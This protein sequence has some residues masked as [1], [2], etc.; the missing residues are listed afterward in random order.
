[1]I[2]NSAECVNQI[3]ICSDCNQALS[4]ICE[5]VADENNNASTL[6]VEK[7][8]THQRTAKNNKNYFK[9]GGSCFEY[10]FVLQADVIFTNVHRVKTGLFNK[11]NSVS[12]MYRWFIL[13]AMEH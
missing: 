9:R 8:K 13:N 4:R 6:V 11:S 1:M 7:V 10:Y 5:T 3:C 2:H 12:F